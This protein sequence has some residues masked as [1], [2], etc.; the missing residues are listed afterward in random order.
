MDGRVKTLHPKV[1]G[2][3]LGILDNANHQAQAAQNDISSIDLLIVNLYPF[4][5]TVNSGHGHDEIVENIDIGGPAMIRSAAK[6]YQYKTIIMDPKDYDGLMQEM[7]NNAMCDSATVY[8]FAGLLG[9]PSFAFYD[10]DTKSDI[11]RTYLDMMKQHPPATTETI[12][13]KTSMMASE[14]K[15]VINKKII[16][17]IPQN[18]KWVLKN[19]M[20]ILTPI[21]QLTKKRFSFF[22]S[23]LG[24]L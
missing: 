13:E 9:V 20:H 14:M 3:L 5:A 4:T 15:D 7:K 10:E 22:L 18:R 19:K 16:P 12:K 21:K 17:L 6:N 1:H 23:S 24:C 8:S 2:A 11:S